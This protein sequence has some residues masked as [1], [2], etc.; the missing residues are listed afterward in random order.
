[1]SFIC[2]VI[3]FLGAFAAAFLVLTL[4]AKRFS[5]IYNHAWLREQ[6]QHAATAADKDRVVYS[7][8]DVIATMDHYYFVG[9]ILLIAFA[10]LM[11]LFAFAFYRYVATA[12]DHLSEPA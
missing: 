2:G 3:F 11:T 7:L 8:L 9:G 6:F 1:L 10:L 4:P 12:A 5:P